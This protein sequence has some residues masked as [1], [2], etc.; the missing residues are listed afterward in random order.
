VKKEEFISILKEHKKII[1]KVSYTYCSDSESRKD[2]EQDIIF[3]L[4]RSIDKFDGRVKL[5][6]WIYKVAFNTS[7]SFFRKQSK[8]SRNTYELDTNFITQTDKNYEEDENIA[9]L[10]SAIKELN[11]FDRAIILLYLDGEKHKS[12]SQIIGISE[13]NVATKINRI[14]KALS[15]IIINQKKLKP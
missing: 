7:I 1:Y 12:I 13:T 15:E 10:Y 9:L 5:S 2:L 6:T 8:I 3:Q 11:E 14:K 4:W